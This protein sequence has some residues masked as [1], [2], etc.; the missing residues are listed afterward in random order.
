MRTIVDIEDI[1]IRECNYFKNEYGEKIVT[2]SFYHKK[3]HHS[4]F[5]TCSKGDYII[6]K[7]KRY[8]Y[9]YNENKLVI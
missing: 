1:N 2:L 5:K 3:F 7:G 6:I 9:P 8:Y 4:V